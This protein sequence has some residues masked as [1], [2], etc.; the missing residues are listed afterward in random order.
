VPLVPCEPLFLKTLKLR[1]P[2]TLA[3]L[4]LQSVAQPFDR[5]LALMQDHTRQLPMMS[6]DLAALRR[7][8]EIRIAVLTLL[9]QRYHNARVLHQDNIEDQSAH[10]PIAI[11]ERVDVDHTVAVLGCEY[12]WVQTSRLLCCAQI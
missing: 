4:L 9:S 11:A 8:R 2:D 1:R 6:S 12:E 5:T 7:D 10:P 3:D